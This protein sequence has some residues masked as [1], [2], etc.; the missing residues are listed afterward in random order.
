M[1]KKLLPFEELTYH[2]TLKKEALLVHLQNEIEAE[3]SFGFGTQRIS[4]SKPYIGKISNPTF[5]LKRAI[6]YRNSF[7]P[8]I[9]GEIKDDSSG[10]KINVKMGLPD[11]VKIFMCIWLGIVFLASLGTLYTLLY[12]NGLKEGP[13]IFIPFVMLFGGVAMV[14]LGF[15]IESKKSITDLEQLLQAKRK[16]NNSS[17]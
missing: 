13:F 15:K 5:E 1:I 8:I 4:Y 9:K 2:S 11:L 3:K 10:S 17:H 14:V 12:N 16:P 7:L 6:S